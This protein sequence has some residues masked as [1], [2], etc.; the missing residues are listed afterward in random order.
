MAARSE[1]ILA[2]SAMSVIKIVLQK[3]PSIQSFYPKAAAET[4]IQGGAFRRPNRGLGLSV[5]G[6]PAQGEG[7]G[8]DRGRLMRRSVTIPSRSLPI[9]A[10]E[11]LPNSL[12]L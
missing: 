9:M 3:I 4:V 7:G 5:Q 11:C 8:P 12:N 2:Y 10:E 6:W 1:T